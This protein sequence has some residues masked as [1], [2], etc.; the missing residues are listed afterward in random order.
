M[1]L[2]IQAVAQ[3]VVTKLTPSLILQRPQKRSHLAEAYMA[4]F[5]K[6]DVNNNVLQVVVVNN[7]ELLDENGQ[8]NEAV[9]AA[10]CRQLF[11]GNWVQTSYNGT[12]RKNYAGIGYVYDKKNDVFYEQQPYKSWI[13]NESKWAWEAPVPY[14]SDNKSYVWNEETISWKELILE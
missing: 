1:A 6:L 13:L 10:F 9:G 11:G 12:I 5:A 7:N 2:L 3:A 4:H 8:E 14:P